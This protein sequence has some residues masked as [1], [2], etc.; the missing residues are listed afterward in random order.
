[1]IRFASAAGERPIRLS[2]ATRRFCWD[3]LNGKYGRELEKSDHLTMRREEAEGLSPYALYDMMISRIAREVP[4]RVI[5]GEMLAG[6]ATL[7]AASRHV[8]PVLYEDGETVIS[9]M[10][11]TTLGFDRVI[12]EGIDSYEERIR[13]RRAQECTDSEDEFLS[14][15]LNVISALR[16]WHGR[17]MEAIEDPE[18]KA[19]LSH[20]P[21][22]PARTFR[23]GLQSLWF[24]FA[25]TRL[26][27]NWPGIGKIDRMLEGLYQADLA[28]GEIAEDEARELLA[29]FFIKGCEWVTLD[30][31][32]SGD[33]QHYQNL[34]LAGVDENGRETAGTV[35]RLILEVVEELPI[36]DFPIAVRMR[37]DSPKWLMELVAR[38]MRHGSGVCSVYNENLVISSLEQYHYPHSDAVQFAND[39]CWEVQIPG[40][41]RFGYMPMDAYILLQRDVLH[42]FDDEE[43]EYAAFDD[44]LSAYLHAMDRD[45]ERFHAIADGQ[46]SSAH[47]SSVFALFEDGCIEKARDYLDG[48]PVY[49]VLSPHY[50]GLPDAANALLA[51]RRTVYEDKEMTLMELVRALRN[52][53]EGQEP[54][55]R[56]IAQREGY[57][58]NDS[59]PA[60]EMCRL[61]V[62]HFIDLA[63]AVHERRGILRPPGISTFGRQIE[64][65][66][67]RGAH[68]QGKKKGEIL[69]GNLNPAPGT[70]RESATAIIR[71]HCS[72]D[73]S[74]LT[75]GT[76]LDIKLEPSCAR[77][78]EGL[79][80]IESLIRG[81]MALG[82]FFMQIDVIDNSQL[83]DAQK[84]PEKYPTLAVRISGW[85]ARF[86]TLDE[87]WQRMIIERTAMGKMG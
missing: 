40:K 11:H 2:E 49:N 15:L 82:G 42:L 64:W 74:R 4:V 68:A 79:M 38:V 63:R 60:D 17:Y 50:G 69:S 8:V 58:G 7:K 37:P 31:C 19:A 30:V 41:T 12:R 73:L 18:E 52:D 35:T 80:G 21:F 56:R 23:E 5:P 72:V 83:L 53:W 70:D 87:N 57:F 45:M 34:V 62:Q 39:G 1:M 75:C 71:S 9:S 81:F 55:R 28:R 65:K 78:E 6:S 47:P 86:V 67:V 84:H 27:G 3:S 24:T 66:D 13:A 54:L 51:I 14:S 29:H 76:A 22:R 10:S 85:S 16:L 33:G 25:F 36:G 77:G 48:G 20:V 61:L 46:I 32:G 44:L 59:A 43:V 26:M